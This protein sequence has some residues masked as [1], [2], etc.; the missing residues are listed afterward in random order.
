MAKRAVSIILTDQ[1]D[2]KLIEDFIASSYEE[3]RRAS[4][5]Q[6]ELAARSDT[7]IRSLMAKHGIA[8]EIEMFVDTS[9]HSNHGLLFLSSMGYT[10]DDTP[11][12]A[13]RIL[14]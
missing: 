3:L 9:Q 1:Q 14:N 4:K 6:E 13:G 11:N 2:R 5:A 12:S 7:I 8:S 10:A